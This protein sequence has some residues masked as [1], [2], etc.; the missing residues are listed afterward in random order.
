MCPTGLD[1]GDPYK[2]AHAKRFYTALKRS[3]GI[4]HWSTHTGKLPSASIQWIGFSSSPPKTTLRLQSHVKP[5]L[6]YTESRRAT[7]VPF[8]AFSPMMDTQSYKCRAMVCEDSQ[9]K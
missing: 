9:H 7:S 2:Q 1:L 6:L 3:I 4:K 5:D 8:G